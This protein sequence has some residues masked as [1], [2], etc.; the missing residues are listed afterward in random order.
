MEIL[1]TYLKKNGC[2]IHRDEDAHRIYMDNIEI[3]HD[4][5]DK[6]MGYQ[7]DSL[8]ETYNKEDDPEAIL[9]LITNINNKPIALFRGEIDDDKLNS[10]ITCSTELKKGGVLL[11]FYALLIVNNL[12]PKITELTGGLS[13]G[14]P[15]LSGDLE[16]PEIVAA[17]QKKLYDYH[18]NNGAT[19]N[20]NKFTYK[21]DVVQ[22]KII[23]FFSITGGK[24]RK[25]QRRTFKKRKVIKK[26]KRYS[27]RK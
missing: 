7:L 12:D 18:L 27:R 5:C 17:K 3:C 4:I 22:N 24:K 20:G 9:L 11:R 21:L 14:I 16:S 25:T 2:K 6:Q 19:I 10:D 13:G 1:D 8:Y 23:E 15:P 26:R